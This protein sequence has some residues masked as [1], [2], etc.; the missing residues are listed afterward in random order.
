MAS[1]PG[2]LAFDSETLS[3]S[4]SPNSDNKADSSSVSIAEE[5]ISI[6]VRIPK[7]AQKIRISFHKVSNAKRAY[8]AIVQN[9]HFDSVIRVAR[10]KMR[11]K[12]AQRLYLPN[13]T[14]ITPAN[15]SEL[16][17]DGAKVYVSTDKPYQ[18][19]TIEMHDHGDG[20]GN[21]DTKMQDVDKDAFAGKGIGLNCGGSFND[22][23]MRVIAPRALVEDEA[24]EQ[25]RNV[26][27]RL[28]NIRFA[29]GMPDLHVGAT[30]PV[31]TAF[32]T[33]DII[34]PHLIGTDIGCGMSL[35]QTTIQ[36]NMAYGRRLTKLLTMATSIDGPWPGS[37][38]KWRTQAQQW[39][40][41][42]AVAPVSTEALDGLGINVSDFDHSLG[43]VGGGN[44]FCELQRIER[45]EDA[46]TFAELNMSPDYLYL[47]VHSGSRGL[48]KA[49]L[50]HH[51]SNHGVAGLLAGSDD[52][53]K[54]LTQHDAACQWARRNRALIAKRFLQT[55]GSDVKDANC[56][57]D[58]WH[59]MVVEREFYDENSEPQPAAHD[60]DEPSTENL[61][62]HRKGAAPSDA[63]LIVIP[64][65]RGAFS[66]LVR[67]TTD[68]AHAQLSAYSLAHGAGRKW[69][70]S[71]ARAST[72]SRYPNHR[73][74]LRTELDSRV[75]CDSPD[76]LYEETPQAYK[77]ITE[78]I[79]DLVKRELCTVVCI[80]RPVITY[81]TYQSKKSHSRK[82][83]HR[84]HV[85]PT[86]L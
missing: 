30:Y 82:V 65:S 33:K 49:I 29:V 16:V 44:H 63:G 9:D 1:A 22:V 55:L 73:K 18:P 78:V 38:E 4:R 52:A 86:L 58:V 35:L 84:A 25:I 21:G 83:N 45:V 51:T 36:E 28:S 80:L 85:V 7:R 17:I 79:A 59:N 50:D 11:F 27:G 34:Y 53:K 13:G 23:I 6:T 46:K 10:N 75:L 5:P 3:P 8:P 26:V 81:K 56:I 61:W 62:L 37:A 47:M 12:K 70:R 57:L 19:R 2:G 24:I 64:G 68:A 31:G 69:S 41:G 77:D 42:T 43:T 40:A 14:E 72:R 48:G 32:A 20:D 76:L 71:K 15:V 67:P 54:Y 60:A 66:Y 39:P 74:L